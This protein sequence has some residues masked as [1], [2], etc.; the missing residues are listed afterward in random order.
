[1]V[2]P[3]GWGVAGAAVVLLAGGI[4]WDY[5]AFVLL[6]LAC[7]AALLLAVLWLAY[8]PR[9]GVTRDVEPIRVEQGEGSRGILTLRNKSARRSP[10]VLAQERLSSRVIDLPLPSLPGKGTHVATY[11]LPTDRRGVFPV[12]PLSVGHTDPLRLLRTEQRF[13]SEAVLT[14][15]PRVHAVAPLPSGR[16]AD[17]EGPTSSSAPRGGVAFHSLREYEPGDDF[18]LIHARATARTGTLMVRHNVIPHEPRL[19][20]V[21]DTR[22]DSY[23]DEESFEDAVRVAASLTV[24]AIDGRFPLVLHTTGGDVEVV[25]RTGER[26]AA[27]DLLARAQT[28]ADDPG[29]LHLPRLAPR[30]EG[31]SLGVATGQP[32]PQFRAAISMV[33]GAFQMVS[34]VQVGE[35][36]GRRSAPLDGALVVNVPTSEDF[37]AAWNALVRR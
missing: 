1:V 17:A 13:E 9:L 26:G 18:R 15:Y 35:K 34:V 28:S 24:A 4:W 5:P 21:L 37:A 10:P 16:S 30:E 14:V 32:S 6:G 23:P 12:G 3:S 22:A 29:L 7:V 36:F 31:V 27:L 2:T 19:M 11:T 20:V 8:P 25:D 33:R